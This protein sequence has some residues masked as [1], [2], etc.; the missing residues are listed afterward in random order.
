MPLDATSETNDIPRAGSVR[1]RV[2]LPGD[3]ATALLLDS[4][5][6]LGRATLVHSFEGT[7]RCFVRV[8]DGLET[9]QGG[10]LLLQKALPQLVVTAARDP[11]VEIDLVWPDPLD[12]SVGPKLAKLGRPVREALLSALLRLEEIVSS[13]V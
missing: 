9:G 4:T 1:F 3:G 2:P 13:Q 7:L 12:V 11:P 6:L 5:G 10:S 8:D